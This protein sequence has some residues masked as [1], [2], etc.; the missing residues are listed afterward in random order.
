MAVVWS[1]ET[2]RDRGLSISNEGTNKASRSFLVRVDDPSTSLSSIAADPGVELGDPHPDDIT[3]TCDSIDVRPSDDDGL[4]Y[5]VSFSYVEAEPEEPEEE[6]PQPGGIDGLI[7]TWGAS[8]SVVS[9]G[10]YK[11]AAGNTM[12]NS[13]GD[14]LE[15]LQAERA[16]FRLTLTQY[17]LSH[18]D[19]GNEIAQRGWLWR[20]RNFTNRVNS[21]NWNGGV[22]GQWKC[23]GSSAR[24]QIDKGGAGGTQRIY[25]EVTWEFAYH[26]D[27]WFLR[28][29]DIGFNELVDENGDPVEV[30]GISTGDGYWDGGGSWDQD[31][32]GSAG[33]C[34]DYNRRS[35]KGVDNKPVRQPVALE[36]G[37]A[38]AACER[39]NALFFEI[40][41]A[42]EFGP[43][44]G[45][46]FTPTA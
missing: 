43:A 4:L 15:D 30:G 44:F 18:A 8:S 29:W 38:K 26:P 37:R 21:D 46:L 36:N 22:Y 17:Y 20:S 5:V 39:P 2:A 32:G 42:V 10:I 34:N 45:E 28:P 14:P 19:T 33:A 12:T 7:P 23:Q 27:G 6:D 25:W 24:L 9:E 41:E 13:A 31:D 3:L 35:I 1:R 40:Y 11:D 16:E